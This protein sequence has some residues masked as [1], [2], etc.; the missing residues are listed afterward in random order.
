VGDE[1]RGPVVVPGRTTD[2]VGGEPLR[3]GAAAER[4]PAS[5]PRSA[6][7]PSTGVTASSSAAAPG[8]PP[9][10]LPPVKAPPVR[11][12]APDSA[13]L[14]AGA[15]ESL[16][17]IVERYV[18]AIARRDAVAMHAAFPEMP[19]DVRQGW[20]TMFKQVR[21]LEAQAMDV[22]PTYGGGDAGTVDVTLLLRFTNPGTRRVCER[23]T[24]LR[25]RLVHGAAGWQIGGMTQGT[26][27]SRGC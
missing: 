6:V 26:G 5:P 13:A 25:V 4:T 1:P 12:P 19:G 3:A 10:T 27:T 23:S 15:E 17:A 8:A 18:A 14:A 21:S 11:P 7:V 16:R 2:A 22:R 24:P 20:E 9:A